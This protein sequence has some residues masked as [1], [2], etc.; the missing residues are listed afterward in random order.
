[1]T[2]RRP[3]YAALR[4][5]A[6]ALAVLWLAVAS[7]AIAP[8]PRTVRVADVAAGSFT[9]LWTVNVPSTGTL[10]VYDDV[11]GLTPAQGV[12][13]ESSS[14]VGGAV[15]AAGEDLGILRARVRGLEASRAYFFRVQTTPKAGGATEGFPAAGAALPS[16]R[17]ATASD[18]APIGALGADLAN[19]ATPLPGAVLLVEVPGALSPL[20][21]A[22]GADAYPAALAAVDLANLH[23]A[24]GGSFAVAGGEI[25]QLQLVAGT[26]GES[27][28]TVALAANDGEGALQRVAAALVA[29]TPADGDGDGIPN[30]VETAAGL[31]PANAADA[32]LDLDGDGLSNLAEYQLG[33]AIGTADSDG[34]GLADGAEVSTHDTL[35][36][37]ADS[38]RDGRSDGAEVGG[39]IVTDPLDADSDGDGVSDGVEVALGTDPNSAASV[40][41]LDADGDGDGD[42]VDNCPSIP[43]AT[44][45]DLDA[46]GDGDACDS[47]DDADGIADGA[48]V[49]PRVADVA[50]LDY[51][52][53]GAGNACDVCPVDSDPFQSDVDGDGDGNAC[54]P[55]SDN[56]GVA[57]RTTPPTPSNQPF[58]VRS[59]GA[60][61]SSTLPTAS[62]PTAFVQISKVLVGQTP[63]RSVTLGYYSLQTRAFLP[64]A[65]SP[66]DAAIEGWLAVGIDP[67]N[68]HCYEV[69]PNDELALSTDVGPVT[70]RLP[71]SEIQLSATLNTAQAGTSGSGG[72]GSG[73]GAFTVRRVNRLFLYTLAVSGTHTASNP[74]RQLLGPA[75]PGAT[76]PLIASLAQ[77]TAATSVCTNPTTA[78]PCITL[79][80]ANATAMFRGRT[81]VR[82]RTAGF[83]NGEIRGQIGLVASPV[84]NVGIT[85]TLLQVALDGAT[86]KKFVASPPRLDENVSRGDI[87]IPLDNCPLH[88]NPSQLD[89]NGDGAGDACSITPT[90]SDGDSVPNATDNCPVLSNIDQA[91]HDTDPDGDACDPDDDNDGILDTPDNCDFDANPDQ[92]NHDA[93]ASGDACDTD[94]DND[95]VLDATDNC[96]INANANQANYDLDPS[97]DVCDLDDDNDGVSDVHETT[98]LGTNPF[99]ADSDDDLILDGEEDEDDDGRKNTQEAIDGTSP[100]APT[101]L[102][103]R[104]ANLVSYPVHPPPGY[105]TTKWTRDLGGFGSV[106]IWGFNP[107]SGGWAV[108]GQS[109][110]PGR[111]YIVVA[112]QQLLWTVKGARYCPTLSLQAGVNAVAP[113]CMPPGSTTYDLLDQIG[114]GTSPRRSR[115]STP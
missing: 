52:Q 29:G 39:P 63:L 106:T 112:N 67:N 80:A 40:P 68:C 107:A 49:C 24:G 18:T 17:T 70:V 108:D 13:V 96:P 42:A 35:P 33:T 59:V 56:D 14:V 93:D 81:Y 50:Q 75:L 98:V 69:R 101:L 88:P 90:D 26:L 5:L 72:T 6:P 34:D 91:N 20:S 27:R 10:A 84:A 9:V 2:P 74:G 32:A 110:V 7:S 62:D 16:V 111:A 19:G 102:L 37:I 54:D 30:A 85:G 109:I 86:Y 95:G 89:S 105:T 71:G 94:D 43:N 100:N 58:R 76:G 103:Q 79:S 55:D 97:G 12:V 4:A 11:M 66:A 28:S 23:G 78:T 114:D 53:D 15:S 25:A 92:A 83:P 99:D 57:D 45:V 87:G 1:M 8:V 3:T 60:V 46:D 65:V 44:Q 77:T 51:D 64:E 38:D 41:F 73:T 47:D 22:A 115:R 31:N 82:A 48:D 61:T 104:G 21:A 36:T 113:G